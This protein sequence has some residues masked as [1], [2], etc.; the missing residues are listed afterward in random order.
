MLQHIITFLA[1]R[2]LAEADTPSGALG[3][4]A[5]GLRTRSRYRR[6]L[7][8]L[9]GLDQRELDELGIDSADFPALAQRHVSGQPPLMRPYH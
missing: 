8:E 2:G 6:A 1:P 4:L 7:R 5:E 3:R 9:N